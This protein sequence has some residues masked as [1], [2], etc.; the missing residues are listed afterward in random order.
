MRLSKLAGIVGSMP[1][2]GSL[3]PEPN[4]TSCRV[5]LALLE[6][7]QVVRPMRHGEANAELSG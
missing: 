4:G 3:P 2:A 6:R 1:I 5:R 7:W